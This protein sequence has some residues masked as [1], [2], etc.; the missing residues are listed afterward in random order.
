MCRTRRRTWRPRR[1]SFAASPPPGAARGR[2]APAL[3]ALVA[4]AALAAPPGAATELTGA[5]SLAQGAWRLAGAPAQSGPWKAGLPAGLA[6]A[7]CPE[8]RW[9]R[10]GSRREGGVPAP[11]ASWA[12]R[13]P[14]ALGEGEAFLS[15]LVVPG[16]AQYRMG[17]RRWIA[18]AGVEALAVVAHAVRRSEAREARRDYRD[19]AWNGARR[20]VGQGA[21]R[22]AGFEYYEAMAHW[23][24]SG[25]WDAEPARPGLQPE[26]DPATFNGSVWALA[27]ALHGV[28][29]AG[30]DPSPG[31]ERA[32]D[33]Y[34]ERAHGPEFLWDWRGS[35]ERERF[36]GL[37]GRSDRLFGAARR[38]LW[39]VVANHLA[40][41]LDGF[42]SARLAALPDRRLGIVVAARVR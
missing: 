20:G 19:L 34:R 13:E 1:P 41:A 38:A 4:S 23:G 26:T 30:Q 39:I 22:D 21:R 16:L 24:A 2:S 42:V 12:E 28:S 11:P 35:A 6:L 27:A 31:F 29:G 40:S 3:V 14:G 15:S 8:S 36:A 7:A 25:A 18:Y 33:Y 17:S 32:L 5:G 10:A 9:A 37:I